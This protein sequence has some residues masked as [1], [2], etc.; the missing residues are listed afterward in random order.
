[1]CSGLMLPPWRAYPAFL[2]HK[3]LVWMTWLDDLV[4]SVLQWMS[5]TQEELLIVFD[6]ADNLP[7][8]VVE[9]FIP[10]GT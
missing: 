5:G 6:N 2:L 8:Y 10:A 1:M 9:R 4:E 3:H 7:V